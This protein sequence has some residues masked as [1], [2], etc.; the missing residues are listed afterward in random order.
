[1][2]TSHFS[3]IGIN[4]VRDPLDPHIATAVLYIDEI[5]PNSTPDYEKFDALYLTIVVEDKNQEINSGTASG[6]KMYLA[7]KAD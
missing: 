1:M 3:C 6:K 7:D 5:N 4:T 2:L